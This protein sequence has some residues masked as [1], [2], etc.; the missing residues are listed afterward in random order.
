MIE[1]EANNRLHQAPAPS[2]FSKTAVK[3]LRQRYIRR[4]DSGTSVEDIDGMLARVARAI[5]ARKG[6]AE[7]VRISTFPL[8]ASRI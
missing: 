5:A 3:V 6:S 8:H 4:D 1:E 7:R 2:P